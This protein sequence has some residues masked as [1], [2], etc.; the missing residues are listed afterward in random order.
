MF[1]VKFLFCARSCHLAAR[2]LDV[3]EK[4]SSVK[5]SLRPDAYS[6]Q[7]LVCKEEWGCRGG[8]FL[9]NRGILVTDLWLTQAR[10]LGR[11]RRVDWGV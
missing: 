10:A 3:M 5:S 6:E 4:S 9:L 1:V 2:H 8:L 7:K 11:K